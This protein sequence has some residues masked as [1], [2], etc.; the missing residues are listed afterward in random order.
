[1]LLHLHPHQEQAPSWVPAHHPLCLTEWAA[2]QLAPLAAA[3]GLLAW[4]GA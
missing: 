3:C 4:T 1:M 2:K